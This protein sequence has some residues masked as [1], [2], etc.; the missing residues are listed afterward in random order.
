MASEMVMQPNE[1]IYNGLMRIKA[2]NWLLSKLIVDYLWMMNE[3]H[4]GSIYF[5]Q[6]INLD[7]KKKSGLLA[8]PLVNN[9]N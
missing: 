5:I 7:S 6:T 4:I 1:G 2:N 8:V 9:I 3:A